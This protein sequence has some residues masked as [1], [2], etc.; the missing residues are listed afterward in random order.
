MDYLPC[1]EVEPASPATATVI[2]LHGLGADGHDFEPIVPELGIAADVP[3]RFV[4]PHAPAIPVTINNGHVMPAWYDIL[5]MNLERRVDEAQLRASAAA[6]AHLIARE[7]ER[8]I[9]PERIVIAGFSQG[10]AVA[11]ELALSYPQRLAGLIALSTYFAT[12]NSVVVHPAN[13]DLPILIGHG[14]HDEMVTESFGQASHQHLS[15]MG[16]A[17]EYRTYA[18]AHG[19]DLAEIR[20]IGAWINAR[21]R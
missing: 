8:G 16:Y 4:F 20:D 18:V 10:G 17:V 6:I 9:G 2:W 13:A 19:I 14:L 5:E 3:V 21:L 15:E 7:G 12:R 1:V 11:Y